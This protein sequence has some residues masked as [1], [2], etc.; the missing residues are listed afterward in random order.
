[1]IIDH[2]GLFIWFYV[3]QLE[4]LQSPTVSVEATQQNMHLNHKI[5][6]AI[7]V[8]VLI[9]CIFKREIS[10]KFRPCDANK[11]WHRE[12]AR[13]VCFWRSREESISG[14]APLFT[15]S[16]CSFKLW[17]G[18][19]DAQKQFKAAGT[20]KKLKYNLSWVF[21]VIEDVQT[22]NTYFLSN[23]SDPGHCRMIRMEKWP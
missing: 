13:S 9:K 19:V 8:K 16:C 21:S 10:F 18:M 4:A 22:V 3:Y 7:K 11:K 20:T 14:S 5:L 23:V 15:F 12:N 17:R 2:F 1:M 6:A